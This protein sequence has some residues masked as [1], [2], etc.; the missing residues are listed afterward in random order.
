[1]RLTDHITI[2]FNSNT[3][4]AAVFLDT[5]KFFDTTWHLGLLY[6][7]SELFLISLIKLI[8]SFL[9][10]RKC[11]VSVE[12]EISMPR[13]IKA[14]VPQGSILSPHIVQHIQAYLGDIA[15]SVPDHRNKA[16]HTHFFGFPVHI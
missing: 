4:T 12:G 2:D 8:S 15:D 3:Y 11:R 16:S 10:H 1:M 13:D 9:S 14:R 6:K 5:E 7:L